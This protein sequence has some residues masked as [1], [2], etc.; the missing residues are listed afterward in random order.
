M[1][2]SVAVVARLQLKSCAC[3]VGVKLSAPT[4][5]AIVRARVLVMVCILVCGHKQPRRVQVASCCTFGAVSQLELRLEGMSYPSF[6]SPA[7][8]T[9]CRATPK[10]CLIRFCDS[11]AELIYFDLHGDAAIQG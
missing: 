5:S 4:A 10:N 8:V 3:A 2:I 6:T 7:R 11:N 1:A 9:S